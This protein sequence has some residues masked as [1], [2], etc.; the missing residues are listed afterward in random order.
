M[1][2]VP[3]QMLHAWKLGFTHPRTNERLFFEA[4]ARARLPAMAYDYY[5]SGAD[6][7][8][9]LRRNRDAF[10]RALGEFGAVSV[11]SGRIL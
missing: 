4:E 3:R 1:N 9:T 11:V 10:A 8:H 7:E 6:E 2:A 5:R